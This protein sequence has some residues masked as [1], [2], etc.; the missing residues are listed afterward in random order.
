MFANVL[1]RFE[2]FENLPSELRNRIYKI[3]LKHKGPIQIIYPQN[4][5]WTGVATLNFAAILATNKAISA[6]A[7]GYLYS[8]NTFAV[9]RVEQLNEFV[10]R[11][12]AGYRSFI[13]SIEIVISPLPELYHYTSRPERLHLHH[14]LIEAFDLKRVCSTVC[15]NFASVVNVTIR[16]MPP[17]LAKRYSHNGRKV[18]TGYTN[19]VAGALSVL[20]DGM[21]G[22]QPMRVKRLSWLQYDDEDW[23]PTAVNPR[24][25]TDAWNIPSLVEGHRADLKDENGFYK[26]LVVSEADLEAFYETVGVGHE[27]LS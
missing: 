22:V 26:P 8:L 17:V 27:G 3:V 11:V 9:G 7:K 15:L 4:M 21:D 1:T 19:D 13:T 5:W 25:P 14:S 20:L 16:T 24:G 23:L 10:A 6:E 2:Y 12:P 18:H